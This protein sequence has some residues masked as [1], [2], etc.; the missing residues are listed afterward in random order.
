MREFSYLVNPL[1]RIMRTHSLVLLIAISLSAGA[2][3]DRSSQESPTV[4]S[5]ALIT[6]N[7]L[8]YEDSLRNAWTAMMHD[9]DQKLDAMQR[10]LAELRG[11]ANAADLDVYG[12]Q[13]TQLKKIRYTRKSMR[14]A[15]VIE[16]YDFASV[17][18]VREIVNAA[19]VSPG[20]A[21]NKSVQ[22][23]V[24]DIR[25]AEERIDNYRADYDD[26]VNHY[27]AF[28]E[29]NK[30]Y[31]GKPYRDSLEKKPMFQIVSLELGK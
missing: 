3:S 27:N 30:V 16:E 24:E 9:D 17:A 21:T 18:L 15:D 22:A 23:L 25:L 19:E 20:Y 28:I 4:A 6:G 10:L 5:E 26:L 31:L 1:Q 12:D 2:C 11:T 29:V 14:N 7:Y 13:L 8:E